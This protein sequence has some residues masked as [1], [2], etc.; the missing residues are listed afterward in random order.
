MGQ[1]GIALDVT[2][3]EDIARNPISGLAQS[4]RWMLGEVRNGTYH[5]GIYKAFVGFASNVYSFLTTGRKTES[6]YCRWH[7]V[8]CSVGAEYLSHTGMRIFHAGPAL[9]FLNL[10][11]S[12]LA[13]W[14][15]GLVLSVG[16]VFAGQYLLLF[17][18]LALFII[19]KGFLILDKIPSCGLGHICGAHFASA[20]SDN[21]EKELC[22]DLEDPSTTPS[23][24]GRL[25]KKIDL[26]A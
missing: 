20:D 16:D 18:I 7:E 17:V 12:V 19:P 22:E 13:Q 5:D 9:L 4:T 24:N 3:Y 25:H 21:Y 6:P 10:C 26:D 8:P 2:L 14:N 11:T 1:P 23:R 15:L